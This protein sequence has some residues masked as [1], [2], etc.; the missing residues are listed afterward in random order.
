MSDSSSTQLFYRPE[1]A[2]GETPSA[3][4]PLLPL[5]EFRFTN[6]SL[7][8]AAQ[9]AVSEE[10]RSDRQV[11]DI[12]RTG[13]ETGGDVGIEFSFGA[14][15]DLFEGALYNDWTTEADS[16]TV[17]PTG[18]FTVAGSPDGT[19]ISA[20]SP[21]SMIAFLDGLT[22]GSFIEIT[23]STLSPVNDGFVRVTANSGSGS[24]TVSP[25]LPSVGTDAFRVRAS[26]LRNGVTLKSFLLEK[27][28]T[29][30]SE[31]VTF[32]GMRV[33]SAQL[34]IAPGSILNGQFS[35]QGENATAQGASVNAG[36]TSPETVAVAANDVFNAVDNIGDILIDGALDPNVCF[37]EVSFNIENNLR[38]QPCVGQLESSGI[39]VGRTQITGTLAAY[40]VNRAFYERYLNFTTTAL[41]F[42]VT[43]GGNTYLIDFP[44]FKFTNGEVVAAGNDQD[45]LVNMEFTAKRDPTLGFTMGMNRFG[46]IPSIVA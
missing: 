23:G 42:T 33:G 43:L 25:A 10:I 27:A 3:A 15:D 9:T 24:I 29:D 11:A 22:V 20:G 41:S 6:E 18:P 44:S 39:G 1:G 8:F 4:S 45:V 5:R 2:W 35:F 34:N 40:F 36:L 32:T 37:T 26:H 46:T 19:T 13:V 30:V 14:H 17:S 28:F 31:F 21:N 7:N 12:I 16:D 38:F